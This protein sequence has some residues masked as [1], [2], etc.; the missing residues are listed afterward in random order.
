[1]LLPLLL[2]AASAGIKIAKG[3][4]QNNLA[5]Q[6]V[7][8]NASYT[9]SPFAQ[10]TLDLAKQ[11]FNS[12]MPGEQTAIENIKGNQA[13]TQAGVERNSGSGAESLAMLAA[14]QGITN[15]AFTG[16]QEKEAAYKAQQFNNL[17]SANQGMTAEEDK[18]YQDAV[19]KQMLA[20]NEKSGLRTA[21]TANWGNGM[22][23]LVSTAFMYDQMKKK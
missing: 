12:E 5:N 1:M 11:I 4:H 6:V 9:R 13:N 18:I 19:R 2:S 20:I 7:V 16:L 8:P 15:N 10:N 23:D 14:G 22:N 3:I 17:A 21:S